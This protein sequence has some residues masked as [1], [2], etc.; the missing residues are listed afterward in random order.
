MSRGTL[1]YLYQPDLKDYELG[2]FKGIASIKDQGTL[3]SIGGGAKPR[4]FLA[5]AYGSFGGTGYVDIDD[6]DIGYLI[7]GNDANTPA[8]AGGYLLTVSTAM[9]IEFH[10]WAAGGGAYS[11][12]S[13]H[14]Q[15]GN[16][17]Y[18]KYTMDLQANQSVG[19]YLPG[20]NG[21]PTTDAAKNAACWPDAGNGGPGSANYGYSGGGSARLGPWFTSLSDM[22]ASTAVYYAI[23]GGGG[24]AHPYGADAGHG[25]GTNG[26]SSPD[27]SY[28]AGGGGGGTQT[29]GGQ[30]GVAS[31]YGGTGQNGSKYQGGNGRQHNVYG[32]GGGGGGGL[33][34]GGSGGTVY[35][36]GGGGSGFVNTSTTGY[37]SG[38]TYIGNSSTAL[39]GD[40]YN[41]PSQAGE[42]GKRGAIFFKKV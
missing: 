4:L 7:N 33:Y 12:S 20:W 38:A 9:R 22:N 11:T 32:G 39:A 34:G 10:L 36:S 30:G 13:V 19:L 8:N 35:A 27:G 1:G 5:A 16:G 41:R 24:G 31:S 21:V 6:I 29:A 18:T 17:G 40:G 37:V 26:T 14:I 25:G 3:N 15:G 42:V 23:A 28:S 2:D